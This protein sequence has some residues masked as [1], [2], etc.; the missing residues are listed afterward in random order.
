MCGIAGYVGS[1]K[2][3]DERVTACLGLMRRRGPDH[4]AGCHWQ[5]RDDR[6]VY[7]LHTR[8]T[9]IDFDERANQPTTTSSSGRN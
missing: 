6:H 7:L 1:L 9:I 3:P 4:A 5:P 8:L 2:I